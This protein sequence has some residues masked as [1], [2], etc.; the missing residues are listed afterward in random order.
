MAKKAAILS[1]CLAA[2]GLLLAW[3]LPLVPV[4]KNEVRVKIHKEFKTAREITS[5]L[6]QNGVLRYPK[7]FEEVLQL[8]SWDKKI[9]K[10]TYLFRTPEPWPSLIKKL[11]KGLTFTVKV[12]IP[13]GWRATQIAERL[14]AEGITAAREF[15]REI[16]R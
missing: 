13:E 14:E 11:I 6:E 4:S 9:K 12:T 16:G 15:L 8:C 3:V 2:L 1:I 5:Y 7:L 10:G